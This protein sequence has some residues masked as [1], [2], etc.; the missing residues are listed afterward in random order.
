MAQIPDALVATYDAVRFDA[1]DAPTVTQSGRLV[2]TR[3]PCETVEFDVPL[4]QVVDTAA[5]TFGPRDDDG[6]FV[7]VAA[8]AQVLRVWVSETLPVDA[9]R[10]CDGEL[11]RRADEPRPPPP[12]PEVADPHNM[13]GVWQAKVGSNFIFTITVTGRTLTRTLHHNKIPVWEHANEYANTTT[14]RGG[15]VFVRVVGRATGGWL[16][17]VLKR[18]GDDHVDWWGSDF[19]PK[20]AAGPTRYSRV[21]DTCVF[22]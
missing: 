6:T 16:Y 17:N 7:H 8:E 18:A 12:E 4:V 2:A 9:G 1:A 22:S 11:R 21:R 13:Q 5:A 20:L 10:Q 3:V 14:D 19:L 15:A